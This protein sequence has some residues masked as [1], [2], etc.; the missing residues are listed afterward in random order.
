[1]INTKPNTYF[2][3]IFFTVIIASLSSCK[4]REFFTFE[5]YNISTNNLPNCKNEDCALLEI[6]LVRIAEGGQIS[7]SINKEIENT[8][9]TILN[10]GDHPPQNTI[11]QAML[12]FNNSFIKINNEFP[13]ETIPHEANIDCNI[14]F[15][16]PNIIS[17]LIDSYIF[18]GGAHG[19]G[20][21]TYINLNP[22]TGKRL[23]N[24]SLF[25]NMKAFESYAERV[26]RSKHK[27][28]ENESINSTG[29]FFE[30]D[31]FS[32]PENIGFTDS[33]II[34]YYNPY[35][36]SSYA[37]GPIE[38]KIPKEDVVS[39]MALEVE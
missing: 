35:E 32:L 7:E 19:Y 4:T 33:A 21:V 6:N 39:F 29:F 8:A 37:D 22:K 20:S 16:S 14:N 31:K 2:K 36:I 11:D 17:I 9:C 28:L 23:T 15:Q 5:T 12:A 3:L 26:F 25:K 10:I 18:T 1:M 30:N 27:I 24:K 13:D 38:L 34:L